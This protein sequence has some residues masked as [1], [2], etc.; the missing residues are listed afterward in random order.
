[1]ETVCLPS[2]L[3][4]FVAAL[5]AASVFM[6]GVFLW[7][8]ARGRYDVIDIAWGVVFIVIAV[9]TYILGDPGALQL[10]LLLLVAAWGLRLSLHI[11]RRWRRSDK[12]DH[13]YQQLRRDYTKKRGGV[14]W[15]MYG[16]VF[17][18]QALLAV[19][20]CTPVIIAMG[21]E[22]ALIGAWALVGACIWCIGF[23]FEAVGDWQ[24][25][26]FLSD[27]SNKG[28]IMTRGL[29][30]YTRHPNYFGEMT[31]WWG[32]F[33][34][35]LS[36]EYGWAGLLGPLVI[37]WLL[38]FISGVPLTERHFRGRPGWDEYVRRT[39]KLIPL[40]PRSDD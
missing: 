13:R 35:A 24:L 18:V 1:M 26:K 37:T 3:V 27:S 38:V 2:M 33:V 6:T 15:N 14:V 11:Y 12:E 31:Q 16:K 25:R 7:A 39:S 34:I 28:K 30:K 8:R 40:P 17:L 22:P 9:T 21:S 23:Y 32:I 29:W 5:A 20:V 36:V 19:V 4:S 10:L